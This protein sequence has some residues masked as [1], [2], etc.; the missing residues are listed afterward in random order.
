[1]NGA[2]S[3]VVLLH[4]TPT[5]GQ[6]TAT[7]GKHTVGLLLFL[8][9]E[10]DRT[11]HANANGQKLEL[12]LSRAMTAEGFTASVAAPACALGEPGHGQAVENAVVLVVFLK[13]KTESRR[14]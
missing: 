7:L 12:S 3:P 8:L 13:R 2:K 4:K 6:T 9:R 11:S 5:L 10:T 1:M 14:H